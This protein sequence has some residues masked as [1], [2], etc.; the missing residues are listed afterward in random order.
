[1]R[2]FSSVAQAEFIVLASLPKLSKIFYYGHCDRPDCS[3]Y[4]DYYDFTSRSNCHSYRDFTGHWNRHSSF[5][6]WTGYQLQET[7]SKIASKAPSTLVSSTRKLPRLSL[8]FCITVLFW[9]GIFYHVVTFLVI[10]ETIDIT[11]VFTS[12]AGNVGDLS[13]RYQVENSE[14]LSQKSRIDAWNL[15]TVV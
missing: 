5:R 11:Q 8:V 4:Y 15:A 7:C 2:S 1:M 3:N 14:D 10:I 9:L 12:C 6:N 13:W